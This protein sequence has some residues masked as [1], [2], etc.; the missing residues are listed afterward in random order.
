MPR[1]GKGRE[2]HTRADR[3]RTGMIMALT[4]PAISTVCLSC[5][6]TVAV[7]TKPNWCVSDMNDEDEWGW[8]GCEERQEAPVF[9]YRTLPRQAMEP[10]DVPAAGWSDAEWSAFLAC[11]DGTTVVQKTDTSNRQA[12]CVD[13][14]GDRHGWSITLR[15]DGAVAELSQWNHGK[16]HG[17][18]IR[19]NILSVDGT[20][21]PATVTKYAHGERRGLYL[22]VSRAMVVKR[23][24]Y[25]E[26][27][28]D[29]CWWA[30]YSNG[31]EFWSGSYDHNVPVGVWKSWR[32]T[33]PWAL[34]D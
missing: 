25:L 3:R 2:A 20:E 34:S 12:S 5:W 24:N 10:P 1:G 32:P 27:A 7:P 11:Q 18:T 13:A 28:R 33:T 21:P 9:Q 29:D 23:G 22:E 26:D 4:L 8:Q 16:R 6:R 17:L 31:R 30:W 15:S 19:G 14:S